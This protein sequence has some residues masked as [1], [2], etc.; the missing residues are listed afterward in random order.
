VEVAVVGGGITGLFTAYYLQK[1]GAEVTLFEKK[2]LGYDSVHAAGII[3][4]ENYYRTN[5]VAYLR[6]AWKYWRNGST[7]FRSID[8]RWLFGFFRFFGRDPSAAGWKTIEDMGHFSFDAYTS[9]ADARN[10][11]GFRM[12]GLIE[13]YEKENGL[14]DAIKAA[15]EKKPPV[16]YEVREAKGW[17]GTV[18]FPHMGWLDTELFVR[19]MEKELSKVKVVHHGVDR[20]FLDGSLAVEDHDRKFDAI[21]VSTGVA[22]RRLGLPLTAVKGY[23]WHAKPTTKLDVAKIFA[24]RGL[25]VVPLGDL[26][27]VTGGWDFDLSDRVK[28]ADFIL[29]CA[30][31]LIGIENV[32]D[33]KS[34][35]RPCSPDGLPIIGRKENVVVANGGF[36][37]GW[38]F[39]PAMGREAALL[40]V[41]KSQNDPF[42]NRFCGGLRSGQV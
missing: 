22:C 37:L 11:F 38:S 18:Y 29:N 16:K 17:V 21:V 12:G 6:R 15:K 3:E 4:P 14:R 34:G 40:A 25:A 1:E 7:S 32:I 23:G 30:K 5:N 31:R 33:F 2:E 10:D 42:L 24:D 20:I 26:V 8:R 9:L 35:S 41:G 39:A 13:H 28:H 19:R 36:R 27:K